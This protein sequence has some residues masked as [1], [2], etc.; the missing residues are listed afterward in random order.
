MPSELT[1]A[2]RQYFDNQRA[3]EE[4]KA[5]WELYFNS[6]CSFTCHE[7]FWNWTKT[8]RRRYNYTIE[9]E[10]VDGTWEKNGTETDGMTEKWDGPSL[11]YSSARNPGCHLTGGLITAALH[12]QHAL[13]WSPFWKLNNSNLNVSTCREG[14]SKRRRRQ[15][16]I[17]TRAHL[18]VPV[19][20]QVGKFSLFKALT[21]NAPRWNLRF[22]FITA[23][24]SYHFI[25]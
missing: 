7:N 8:G 24:S 25:V 19:L 12:Q 6:S 9:T 4:E 13:T 2:S 15:W 23:L 10:T 22:N 20:N 5:W 16:G 21:L 18:E 1:T 17:T 3:H 14:K 11:P